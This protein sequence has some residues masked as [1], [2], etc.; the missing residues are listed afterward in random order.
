MQLLRSRSGQVALAIGGVVALAL[1]IWLILWISF[2]GLWP[3]VRDIALVALAVITMVP[4]LALAYAVL[5][6][7]RT[8]ITLRREL[9][10]LL[11]ELKETTQTVSETAKVATNFT[12]KPTVRTAS[13][14]VG[15]SQAATIILGRG[16][17]R[18]DAERRRKTREAATH[19]AAN[20]LED[21]LDDHR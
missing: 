1:L 5:E 20:H 8:A 18:R 13:F 14:L 3:F 16:E 19:A 21:A 15:F 6:L 11:H 12:I 9:T 7:A 2:N 17:G 10:P 4:L